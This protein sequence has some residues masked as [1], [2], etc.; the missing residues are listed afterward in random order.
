[1]RLNHPN[2][3]LGGMLLL[4]FPQ[5]ILHELDAWS[6][7]MPQPI[8]GSNDGVYHWHPPTFAHARINTNRSSIS[9]DPVEDS[10][11]PDLY[12]SWPGI[13]RRTASEDPGGLWRKRF[14]N[15]VDCTN[16]NNS[17]N[18]TP[19]KKAHTKHR[20]KRISLGITRHVDKGKSHQD[21]LEMLRTLAEAASTSS[22]S[23]NSSH[24]ISNNDGTL[25]SDGLQGD[26]YFNLTASS[27]HDHHHHDNSNSDN[28]GNNNYDKNNNKNNDNDDNNNQDY[29]L[30]QSFHPF[31]SLSN[32]TVL[33]SSPLSPTSQSLSKQ[34]FQKEFSQHP[35][36]LPSPSP[37]Q[38]KQQP[39]LIKLPSSSFSTSNDQNKFQ[40]RHDKYNNIEWKNEEM[41]MVNRFI[42]DRNIEIIVLI[43]G[44]D[45][46][47]GGVVQARHSYK[48]DDILWNTSFL[49]C[50]SQDELDG[51]PI[52]DFRLFHLTELTAYQNEDH[53]DD[54]ESCHDNNN[55]NT[56]NNNNSYN[57]FTKSYQNDSYSSYGSERV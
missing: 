6:P 19:Q 40:F 37:S 52:I 27:I 3:E 54:L 42:D 2:D 33:S 46:T 25:L 22:H 9:S 43:E 47:T 51:A 8:W 36:P 32:N 35:L 26:S 56:T 13:S 34:P 31:E 15:K 12:T 53:K 5:E 30:E 14:S 39:N 49:P 16:G 20:K 41:N 1:M 45:S 18:N 11:D 44:Q 24:K 23:P 17:I 55:N 7:L 10:Y 29:H 4:C 48:Y 21:Y 50:V 28:D 38:Q 57:T